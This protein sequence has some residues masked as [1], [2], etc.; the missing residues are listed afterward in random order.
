MLN[1]KNSNMEATCNHCNHWN[2]DEEKVKMQSPEFGVCDELTGQ[3]A[4]EPEYVLPLVHEGRMNDKTPE[5]FE[6]ITGAQFGCNH[7][8]QRK[9]WI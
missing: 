2:Q 5:Q 6:M 3:H 9:S 4:M 8:S 1:L 7:F